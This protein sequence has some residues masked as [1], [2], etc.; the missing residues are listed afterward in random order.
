MQIVEV[1]GDAARS[2][3]VTMRRGGTPLE[4][5]IL[6]ML[7]VAAPA[8]HSQIRLRLREC[9][10]VVI[11]GIRGRSARVSALTPA[12]RFAPRRRRNGLQERR[13][14]LLLPGTRR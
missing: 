7:H 8:F 1:T 9:D 11:E 6:A 4:F 3:V 12:H 13:E 10:L 2:A 14:E 5:V